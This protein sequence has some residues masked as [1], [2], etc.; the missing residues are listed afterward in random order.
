MEITTG[1]PTNCKYIH[2][3]KC[4]AT[5]CV[6]RASVTYIIDENGRIIVVND[7]GKDSNPPIIN[8]GFIS[9]TIGG[10]K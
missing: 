2:G 10:N 3:D 7:Y 1:C 5:E 6:R 9:I 8:N 4:I